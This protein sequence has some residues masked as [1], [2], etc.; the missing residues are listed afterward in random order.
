MNSLF[1]NSSRQSA[2]YLHLI[3]AGS[4]KHSSGKTLIHFIPK[5]PA[6]LWSFRDGNAW[7]AVTISTLIEHLAVAAN[8]YWHFGLPRA[9]LL[10]FY[11]ESFRIDM[12]KA[13]RICTKCTKINLTCARIPCDMHEACTQLYLTF[14]W[15]S[16]DS[17]ESAWRCLTGNMREKSCQVSL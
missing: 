2:M 12:R 9:H 16:R 7:F 4:L 17:N 6:E 3:P 1:R 14:T 15:L 5:F 11:T 10:D 13:T 8:L